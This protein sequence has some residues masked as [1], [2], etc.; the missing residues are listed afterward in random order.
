MAEA[1]IFLHD[2]TLEKE[3]ISLVCSTIE[4]ITGRPVTSKIFKRRKNV[5]EPGTTVYVMAEDEEFREW[6][7]HIRH[8][9]IRIAVLPYEKNGL[10]RES[11]A[12]PPDLKEA[13]KLAE[14]ESVH[15]LDHLVLCNGDVVIGCASA[16]ESGWISGRGAKAM[17]K[18]VFESLFSMKLFPLQ[19]E[20]AK[21][22]EITTASLLVEAGAEAVMQAK[23]P[24]FFKE[25]D[26]RCRRIASVIY[27]PQSV[28]GALKLRFFLAKR[29]IN[30]TETLPP[31]VGT[32]KSERITIKSGSTKPIHFTVDGIKR[33]AKEISFE[34]IETKAKIVTGWKG[35]V[36]GEEKESLRIQ[37][38]PQ[39]SDLIN[40][41]TRRTLPL[42]P[43]ASEEAFA[44]LFMKLRNSAKISAGYLLLLLVSVLMA[45]TGLF[46]NSSPT[47]IGAMIL[48]PL[49]APIVAFAMGAVRFD[50]TLMQRSTK[51]I[52]LSVAIAL[53]AS[54][55]YAWLLPFTH[56]TDQMSMRTHPTLLDLAVAVFAGIAAAYG[57]ADSKIGESLAGVAIAVALVP[58]LCV[59]GIGIGWGSWPLF[60]NALLLFLANIV[61]IIVASGAMFY[62]LGYASSRYASTAFF[63]K[64]LMVAVIAIPLYLSTRSVVADEKIYSRFESFKRVVVGGTPV[65]IRL[66]GISHTPDG[67]FAKFSVITPRELNSSEKEKITET[68]HSK[69]GR[70]IGMVITY[71]YRH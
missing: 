13:I 55:L 33:E 14:A 43:I 53:A 70:D 35:C 1:S 17:A 21:E 63:I 54:A 58:P 12:I 31:G 52:L 11:Y 7:E 18:S 56:I 9:D 41:F 59:S 5:F 32:V 40:F 44:E 37:N 48:A 36:S 69:L 46:Q 66:S 27:A 28:L 29:K 6:L 22:K 50:E 49:M 19:I 65:D 8:A 61:G 4:E 45:S 3:K 60:S 10:C 23:R 15:L 24:Y 16:G 20:T 30:P 68:L 34:T 26:N 62:I 57:Y 51:T 67:D 38:L 47:I 39:E 2:H 71:R 42:V 25:S 64:L